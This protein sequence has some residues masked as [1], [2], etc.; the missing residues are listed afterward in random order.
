M[1]GNRSGH[2]LQ[3]DI[4]FFGTIRLGKYPGKYLCLSVSYFL[5]GPTIFICLWWDQFF[6]YLVGPGQPT[7]QYY[8]SLQLLD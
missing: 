6:Y 5:I 2:S 3:P 1:T 4:G 8:S 7:M